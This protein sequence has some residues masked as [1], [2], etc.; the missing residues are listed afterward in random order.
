MLVVEADGGCLID[1]LLPA[2]VR[3][4]P[5]DLVAVDG[6]LD[7]PGV[8]APFR[9]RW[10][11]TALGWGRPSIPIAT[12]LRLM[13]LKHTTGWGYERLM[14]QVSDSLQLRRFC[15][16]AV[17]AEAPDESTVRKLTRRLGPEVVDEAIRAVITGARHQRRFRPRA[18]RADSTVAEADITYPT[19]VG[20][21]ADAVRVL[22]RAARKV[23]AA[24][25]DATRHVVDRSRSVGKRV[26]A[27]GRSLRR[28]N[29]EAR[30]AVQALTEEAAVRVAASVAESMKLLAQARASTQRAEDVSERTRARAITDL[31]AFVDRS[32]R[33]VDQIKLRFAGEKIPNRLVSLF[34]P[35]ALPIRRGKLARPNEFGYMVQFSEVTASTKKGTVSLVLPPKLAAG[36]T[37]ENTLLPQA[38]AEVEALGLTSIREAAFDAGFTRVATTKTLPQLERIFIAG[39][40]S[41]T[42][43]NRTRRRLACYRVGCE[44]RISHLK[45]EY[46]AGRSRLKGEP[47]A[48]IWES[49]AVLAYDVDTVAR[50]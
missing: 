20:L 7:D 48:R 31:G 6:V 29:G 8:V 9:K 28:R 26:R 15:R 1:E 17:I 21:C 32:T 3:L 34:D 16:I 40:R 30:E 18:L 41:N 47:G 27:I 43:S 46:R 22:A 35:D 11:T 50:M 10:E 44:A 25:P 2:E 42:G 33:V 37:P 45:R 38:A 13:Y 4:L 19:D 12:Y 14:D 5:D 39:S 49:W 23:R 24:V 36:S